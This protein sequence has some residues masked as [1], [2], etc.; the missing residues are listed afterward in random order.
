MIAKRAYLLI[1]SFTA[2]AISGFSQEVVTGLQQNTQIYDRQGSRD[3]T[4]SLAEPDTTGLPFFEDFI[5]LDIWPSEMRWTDNDVYINNTYPVNPVSQGVA[6]FDAID[7][8]GLLYDEAGA[9]SF[10]ADHLT[11]VPIDLDLDPSDNV[12][13]SFF[14][15]PQGIADAPEQRDSLVLQFYSVADEQWHHIWKAEGTGL[16]NFKPVIIKIDNPD[17]LYKGFRFRFIN[18]ASISTTIGDPAMAGNSDHWHID[19]IYL[20]RNRS[21]A[22]T[23]P[24]D[25]AFTSPVRSVLNTYESMPWPQ[26]RNVFL[27]EMGSYI[28]INYR[29]NDGVTRN[30]TRNF[31]IK[32]LYEDE[33]VH[34]FSA[35]AT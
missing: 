11:S 26:F 6:T 24:A 34:T 3:M 29:N 2:L 30:V 18:Y 12:F 27:S 7:N 4:K 17:Y 15:Q 19:Y 10:E 14:Y 8:N 1:L 16:H 23:I 13:L 25:V 28:N 31:E 22:D 33:V 35:G 5:P 32:D 21:A 9:F 20:N